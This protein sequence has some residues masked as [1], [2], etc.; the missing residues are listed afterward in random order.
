[1]ALLLLIAQT[2]LFV[3]AMALVGQLL[4]GLFNWR[5]RHENVV[6]QLFGVVARPVVRAVRVVTPR[7]VLDQ[8]VP[9]VAFLLC[10][11]A[12]LATGFAH[13]DVCLSDLSQRGCEKWVQAR[14]Q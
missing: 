13:R 8:H 12:Y 7:L 14:M 5:R 10:M 2:V 1:M 4:I 6:Y 3:A 11:I 9:V